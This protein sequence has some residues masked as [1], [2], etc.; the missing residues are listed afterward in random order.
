M[1][2]NTVTAEHIESIIVEESYINLPGKTLT[3]CV[4]TLE[5]GTNVTGESAC[6]DP[7]IF[8]EGKGREYARKDAVSKVWAREG[9]LLAERMYR[10]AEATQAAHNLAE[11]MAR[12]FA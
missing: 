5:N 10:E 3:I 6:V 12:T 7:A 9:Y 4:L 1:T 8:D 2:E 11:A